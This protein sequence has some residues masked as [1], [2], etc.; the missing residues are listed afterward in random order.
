MPHHILT[1]TSDLIDFCS[2]CLMPFSYFKSFLLLL[3]FLLS[4]LYF[5]LNVGY[6]V[7]PF[8]C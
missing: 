8:D 6:F 3:G 5:L 2:N 7:K 1:F 4:P